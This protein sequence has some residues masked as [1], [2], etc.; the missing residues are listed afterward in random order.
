M[1]AVDH[2]GTVYLRIGVKAPT[3]HYLPPAWVPVDG[4]T[5]GGTIS[6]VATGPE[7]WKVCR[8]LEGFMRYLGFFLNNPLYLVVT[9]SSCC[10]N[11]LSFY[12]FPRYW[13]TLLVSQ[14]DERMEKK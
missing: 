1:W 3:S 5:Q 8:K 12:F 2:E 11:N 4:E 9:L 13:V 14:K 10:L 6:Q 7:D